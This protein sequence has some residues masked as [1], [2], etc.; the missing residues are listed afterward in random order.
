MSFPYEIK[1]SRTGEVIYTATLPDEAASLSDARKKAKAVLLALKEDVNIAW[2]NLGAAYLIGADL[3]GANL[4]DANLGAAYL[5][6]ANLEGA[7][8]GGVDLRG[9]NLEGAN[10]KGANLKSTYLEGARLRGAKIDGHVIK[11]LVCQMWRQADAYEF[12]IFKIEGDDLLVRAGC[13]TRLI[14]DYREH[15]GRDYP[16]TAK[17]EETLALLDYAESR[18]KAMEVAS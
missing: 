15:V 5:R 17:A 8:L 18:A 6:G 11:R 1:H 4:R 7:N 10:L 16:D 3:R 14:S 2:A 13:Q 9:A 12:F